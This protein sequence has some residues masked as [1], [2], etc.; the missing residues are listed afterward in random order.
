MI[1]F[2]FVVLLSSGCI[3]FYEY[4]NGD[5]RKLFKKKNKSLVKPCKLSE[6]N[7]KPHVFNLQPHVFHLQPL[8]LYVEKLHKESSFN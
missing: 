4:V 5:L 8:T 6:K 3:D 2:H 7:P 1:V